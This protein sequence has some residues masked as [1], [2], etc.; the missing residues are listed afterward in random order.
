MYCPR[1]GQQ[2]SENLKF[3]SRCGISLGLIAEF[4]ANGGTLPQLAEI[5]RSKNKLTKKNGM[6]FSLFWILFFVL[7]MTPIFG[8]FDIDELAGISAIIGIFGG[9][10]IFLASAFFLESPPKQIFV[11]N[12]VTP[13]NRN[14][15]GKNFNALPPQQSIPAQDYVSPAGGWRTSNTSDLAQPHSVT[16]GTTKLLQKEEER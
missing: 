1:C 3:C 14:L 7:L 8:V 13:E 15:E 11:Q 2:A 9:L 12:P 16:E 4:L 6:I 10:L 5:Y